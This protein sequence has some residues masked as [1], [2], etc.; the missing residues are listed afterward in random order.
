MMKTLLL[1][2]LLLV[3]TSNAD[4]AKTEVPLATSSDLRAKTF[5]VL[6]LSRGKMGHKGSKGEK[7]EDG[8]V[9]AY[10]ST[11]IESLKQKTASLEGENL[12]LKE[13]T[14]SMNETVFSQSAKIA[15]LEQAKSILFFLIFLRV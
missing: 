6:P 8:V 2:S 15:L 13:S 7:G 10:L 1:F 3:A 9:S 5:S 4:G 11:T 12:A 14:A